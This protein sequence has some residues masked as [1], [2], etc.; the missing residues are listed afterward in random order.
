[1]PKQHRKIAILGCGYVGAALGRALSAKGHD[2]VGTTTTKSRC[3]DIRSL[4]ITPT[5]LTLDDTKRLSQLLADRDL[6]YLT[7]GAGRQKRDYR[8]VY[9]RGAMHLLDAIKNTSVQ[10]IVYTSSTRVYGQND[11]SWVDE[12]S[13]TEPISED[14]KTLVETERL[15][16]E[17]A[18]SQGV[19][20]TVLR[21]SGI[22]GPG[23]DP[24]SRIAQHAGTTRSDGDVFVNLIHIDDIVTAMSALLNIE[25]DGVLNL[26]DDQPTPRRLF[27]NTLIARSALAPIRWTNPAPPTPRGKRIRNNRA[28]R[29]LKLNLTHPTHT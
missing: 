6:V 9:L 21:L 26:S 12:D 22:H 14:G 5:V 19:T 18:R 25:Y 8:E 28:K 11:G 10:Q 4:G 17:G 1:M 24:A 29:E 7:V 23:R 15:L 27:Y 2:C 16:L 3:D 20:A 13:P